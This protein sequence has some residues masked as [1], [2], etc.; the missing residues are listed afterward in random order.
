MDILR[1]QFGMMKMPAI[2]KIVPLVGVVFSPET[3][4]Y[5]TSCKA[6]LSVSRGKFTIVFFVKVA[7]GPLMAEITE[8]ED[9][10]ESGANVVSFT[11]E[12]DIDR[13]DSN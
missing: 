13:I 12:H 3:P 11:N 10:S 6:V 1:G 2:K 5:T 8:S 9:R 4:I 7:G